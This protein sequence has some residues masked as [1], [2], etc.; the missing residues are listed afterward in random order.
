MNEKLK[1]MKRE[2]V[3]V[4]WLAQVAGEKTTPFTEANLELL[5]KTLTN[6]LE[7]VKNCQGD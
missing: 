4:A 1:E 7:A 3:H 5:A 6:A 2:L